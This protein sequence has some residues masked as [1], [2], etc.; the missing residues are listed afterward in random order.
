MAR[1]VAKTVKP[2]PLQKLGRAVPWILIICGIISLVASIAI[3][4][5]K[6]DLLKNP[7]YSPI[8]DLN[9][10]ISCGSV[11]Q[12]VQANAFGFMNTFIGLVGFPIVVTI[13]VAL[14]AGARFKRWFWLGGLGGLGLG[15]LFAYWLL[16]ES[17]YRIGAL[18]PWCL[19]VDVATTIAFWYL[20]LYELQQGW[21]KL[22]ARLQAFAW[23]I[24]KHHLDILIFWFVLVIALILQHFW[25]Y[26][27]RN[28]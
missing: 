15:I 12:S 1:I 27:G 18:C 5:E 7:H 10:I 3:T 20:L 11:M 4:V 28:F 19:S 23:F 17:V 8:C 13:G 26:F 2:S 16:F 21:L 6:I 24:Q 25:Y 22:P 9:P 14:L